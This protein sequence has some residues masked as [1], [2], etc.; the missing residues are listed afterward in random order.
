MTDSD[1]ISIQ[2]Y[3]QLNY[4]PYF[5]MGDFYL[6]FWASMFMKTDLGNTEKI[7]IFTAW[8]ANIILLNGICDGSRQIASL[9]RSRSKIP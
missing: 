5:R 1:K 3:L 2:L 8:A 7:G 9:G 6:Y 4:D